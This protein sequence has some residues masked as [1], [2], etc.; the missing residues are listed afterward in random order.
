MWSAGPCGLV[1]MG[2]PIDA[3]R[4]AGDVSALPEGVS[5]GRRVGGLAAAAAANVVDY[6]MG[7]VDAA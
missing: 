6:L 3:A 4:P 2:R 1:R 5:A 7:F